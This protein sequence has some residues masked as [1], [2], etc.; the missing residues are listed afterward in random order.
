[1]L[2]SVSETLMGTIVKGVKEDKFVLK[3]I[4]YFLYFKNIDYTNIETNFL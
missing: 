3:I 4:Q 2:I 1:M